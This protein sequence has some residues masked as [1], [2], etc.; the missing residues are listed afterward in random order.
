MLIKRL[1]QNLAIETL[2]WT[3]EK[4][5]IHIDHELERIYLFICK[6]CELE[7]C[8]DSVQSSIVCEESV[9]SCSKDDDVTVSV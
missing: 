9:D 4:S 2:L 7:L 3:E 6:F 5:F 8:D 1:F